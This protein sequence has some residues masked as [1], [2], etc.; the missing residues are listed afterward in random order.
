MRRKDKQITD[1]TMMDKILM[2]AEILHLALCDNGMPYALCMN[3]GY[4]GE[5]IYIHGALEGKKMDIL[6]ANPVV[7]FQA[8][9]DY[10]TIKNE[11]ASEFTSYYRSVVGMGHVE[12]LTDLSDKRYGL[13]VLMAAYDPGKTFTFD[14]KTID[15]TAVMRIVIDS[16]DGKV[17]GDF[18][19]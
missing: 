1:R 14:D 2:E 19:E 9:C 17:S 5:A 4:D 6:K 10:Q 12:I 7:S 11:D 16:M 3:F 15:R 18:K 13:D 8:V